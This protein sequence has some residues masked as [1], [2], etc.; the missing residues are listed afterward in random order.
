MLCRSLIQAFHPKALNNNSRTWQVFWL[1][2]TLAAFPLHYNSGVENH[3]FR[4]AEDLTATGI[5]P[6]LHRTSLLIQSRLLP[7]WEPN[8]VQM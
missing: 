6:D 3:G 5:A 8:S 2:L 7:E 4:S 1:D